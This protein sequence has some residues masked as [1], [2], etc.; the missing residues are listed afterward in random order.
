[1]QIGPSSRPRSRVNS[2]ARFFRAQRER[3]W[4]G[5]QNHACGHADHA[6][7]LLL[8]TGLRA[9]PN[10]GL[11][12]ATNGNFYGTTGDGGAKA[13]G[14]VFSLSVALGPFVETLPT[15]GKVGAAVIIL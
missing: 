11:L 9:N 13:D 14:M 2:N 3:L 12:L 7:Q 6:P 1:M 10:T 5:L 8:P 15:S 4:H